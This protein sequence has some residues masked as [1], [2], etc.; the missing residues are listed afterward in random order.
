MVLKA[1]VVKNNDS[2]FKEKNI[3][4][5]NKVLKNK[6]YVKADKLRIIE[7]LQ[8]LVMNAYKF[9]KV[10]KQITFSVKKNNTKT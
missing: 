5:V 10:K 7:V 9:M 6:N 3:T 2:V 1:P 4:I 8:N